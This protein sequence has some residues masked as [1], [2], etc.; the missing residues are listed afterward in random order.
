MY[1]QTSMNY[2]AVYRTEMTGAQIKAMLEDVCDNLFNPNPYYQQG[3]DMVRVGG[4][5]YECA[6]KETIGK[7][8][9]KMVLAKTG[10]PVEADKRYVVG[11]WASVNPDT[12][13]P[14]I[15]DL[16]E[17]Y[18]TRKKVVQPSGAGH[19]KVTGMRK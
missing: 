9:D 12:Q 10:A 16:L 11:G 1:T 3:G 8:I 2:P 5:S 17:N 7:R 4:M 13:G 15:Y 6:P 19:V 14:A 18:I